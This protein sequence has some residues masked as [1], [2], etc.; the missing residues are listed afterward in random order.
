MEPQSVDDSSGPCI[1]PENVDV[2]VD[3]DAAILE[4]LMDGS[5]ELPPWTPVATERAVPPEEV[6]H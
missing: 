2:D 5:V 3:D 6:F 1:D 4:G